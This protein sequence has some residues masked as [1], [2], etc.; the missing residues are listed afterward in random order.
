MRVGQG[1][2]LLETCLLS[3]PGALRTRTLCLETETKMLSVI[4]RAAVQSVL[5]FTE[6]F[7]MV[8]GN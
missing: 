7:H 8:L 2:G 3:C 4:K 1:R 5:Q 6:H